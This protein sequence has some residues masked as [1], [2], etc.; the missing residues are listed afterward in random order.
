MRRQLATALVATGLLAASIIFG[1]PATAG[2]P[3]RQVLTGTDLRDL[4]P[5]RER[6][7]DRAL[8][9]CRKIESAKK[10]RACVRKVRARFRPS[11]VTPEP[12]P[13]GPVTEVLVRDKYFSPTEATVP[14]FG[15]VLWTWGTQNADAHDVNLL[16]GPPGVSLLDFSSPLAPSVNY[17]FKRKFTVPGTYHFGCSLHHLMRMTVEVGD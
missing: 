3:D 11:P 8:A 17:D 1:A 6:A 7:R 2:D 13:D 15:S 9:N 12:T 16:D 5:A 10:R 4:T 14:K